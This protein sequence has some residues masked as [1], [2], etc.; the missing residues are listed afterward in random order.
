MREKRARVLR[1]GTTLKKEEGSWRGAEGRGGRASTRGSC[2]LT[3]KTTNRNGPDGLG[4]V[5]GRERGRGEM[6]RTR[7][8]R[9]KQREE[10]RGVGPTGSVRFGFSFYFFVSVFFSLL[11]SNL[12]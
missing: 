12:F 3:R 4:L 9:E 8:V 5:Q 11:F 6:G 10:E 1:T 2:S 7:P